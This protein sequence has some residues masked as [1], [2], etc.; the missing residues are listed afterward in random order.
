MIPPTQD[1]VPRLQ[2]YKSQLVIKKC[3]LENRHKTQNKYQPQNKMYGKGSKGY[4]YK[5][6]RI[7][8]A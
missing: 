2:F 8:T 3:E 5:G 1:I 6:N 7:G 4:K